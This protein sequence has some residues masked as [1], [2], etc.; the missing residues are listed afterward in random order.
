VDYL[1]IRG[2]SSK[3]HAHL[4]EKAIN[5]AKE[6][7]FQVKRENEK[8]KE[9]PAPSAPAVTSKPV[10]SPAPATAKAPVTTAKTGVTNAKEEAKS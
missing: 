2:T 3:D 4:V 5:L 7:E 8:S 9:L 10:T 1:A 6:I